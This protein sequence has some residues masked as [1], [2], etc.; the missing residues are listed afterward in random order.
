MILGWPL[1]VAAGLARDA[2]MAGQR[3]LVVGGL[4]GAAA[5]AAG[6]ARLTLGSGRDRETAQVLVVA[7]LFL[8][9]G[10]FHGVWP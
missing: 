3:L 9:A 4:V 10:L 5:V 2:A 8:A 7:A 6:G 1:M